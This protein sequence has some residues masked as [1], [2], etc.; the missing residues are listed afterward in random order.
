MIYKLKLSRR[1]KRSLIILLVLVLIGIAESTL[2]FWKASQ[3]EKKQA[4]ANSNQQVSKNTG[5]QGVGPTS[6]Y[7]TDK[8]TSL[9]A[10]V[11]KGRALPG[12][13]IPKQ[14]VV[15]K[16]PLA[17]A[18]G[19]QEMYLRQEAAEALAEMAEAA[20]TGGAN[21]MLA[22]GYRS[23]NFQKNL[24]NSYVSSQGPAQADRTSARPGHSEHQTGLAADLEPSSRQC[25]IEVCFGQLPEGKWLAANAYKYGFIIRYPN[26]KESLTGYDYEPWHVRYVGQDLATKVY[27]SGQTLEQY[28]DLPAA[29]AYP[30]TILTLKES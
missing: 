30:E 4:D 18:V 10:V 12:G 11:N 19:N 27:Q 8:A 7:P 14:L 6:S 23:Y 5:S 17:L 26:G 13:Y 20:K 29:P 25:E 15:P 3:E 16:I 24:Y 1:Y 2:L 9:Q 22:S 21:L 28:F